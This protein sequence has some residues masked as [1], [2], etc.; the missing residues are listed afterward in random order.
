MSKT[1]RRLIANLVEVRPAR[2]VNPS[3]VAL[4]GALAAWPALANSDY[5]TGLFE[6]SPVVRPGQDP[7]DPAGPPPDAAD[8]GQPDASLD[9][10]CASIAGRTFHS[11][12]EVKRAHARCDPNRNAGPVVPPDGAYDQ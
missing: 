10:Y 11:L 4:A 6:N 1:L 8:P 5:P 2:A 7:T 9:D 12:E 3:V